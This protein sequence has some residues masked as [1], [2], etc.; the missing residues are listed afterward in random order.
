MAMNTRIPL[1]GDF[2]ESFQKGIDTGSTLFQRMIQP[3]IQRKQ[4]EQQA[5]IH[6]E[7]QQYK[8]KHLEQ[9]WKQH[10]DS[11]A[12]Q[13]AQEARLSQMQPFNI[14]HMQAQNQHM[15]YQNQDLA[16]QAAERERN[17]AYVEQYMNQYSNQAQAPQQPQIPQPTNMS[18]APWAQPEQPV[19]P[20]SYEQLKQGFGGNKPNVPAPMAA[21]V[22]QA[23][24]F[25]PN[26]QTLKTKPLKEWQNLKRKRL[27]KK[28][29]KKKRI[30]LNPQK[31][32]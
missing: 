26:A 16:A 10:M 9:M 7:E 24:K 14:E 15:G 17:R 32:S 1:P 3:V 2:G 8:Y 5:Q 27:I 4:L 18:V 20:P 31:K 12:I 29:K 13:Q 25:D 6:Q 19:A 11:I 23:L 21:A 30:Y 22:K 28:H